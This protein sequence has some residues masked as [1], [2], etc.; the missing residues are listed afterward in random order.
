MI[1]DTRPFEI[2]DE[3]RA[4][5]ERSVEQ[6]KLA[7]TNFAKA[8][9]EAHS[10]FDHWI[11]E[12]QASAQHLSEKAMGFAQYNVLSAFDFAQKIVKAKD[13]NELIQVRTEFV[14]WQTQALSEQVK[15]FGDAAAKATADGVKGITST[16]EAA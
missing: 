13:L 12:S 15:T 11:T 1:S 5:A 14:Q 8:V 6:A 10:S 7:F 4:L 3:I 2:P 16:A 9:R